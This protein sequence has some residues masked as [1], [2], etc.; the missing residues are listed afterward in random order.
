MRLG[1][2]SAKGVKLCAQ[3]VRV[4]PCTA[5][6]WSTGW[7]CLTRSRRLWQV[8]GQCP[9]GMGPC[10]Q[11]GFAA[12]TGSS[13]RPSGISSGNSQSIFPAFPADAV[14]TNSSLAGV[15]AATVIDAKSWSQ[16]NSF[17]KIFSA[18]ARVVGPG[19]LEAADVFGYWKSTLE[20]TQQPNGIP[21]NPFS[22]FETIGATE[23]VNY[24]MLQSDPGYRDPL[25][26][27]AVG[28]F[29]GLFEA[30]PPMEAAFT[31]LRARG[32]FVVSSSFSN[33]AGVGGWKVGPTVVLSERGEDFVLR[34]PQS[35]AKATLAVS[36]TAGGA[37]PLHWFGA[38]GAEFVR[39]ATQA[40]ET[41]TL[42]G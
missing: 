40:G 29:I 9:K 36:A 19:L 14:G 33:T 4:P 23:F 31:K 12:A 24:M 35:W 42:H 2:L 1:L 38:A 7:T 26:N 41:Y 8:G 27:Q 15:A 39:F 5:P 18:A 37:V 34:R 20:S 6:Q 16:G 32:A 17:S 10:S 13:G 30:M 11:Q 28:R 25:T 3:S 21:F 22:G